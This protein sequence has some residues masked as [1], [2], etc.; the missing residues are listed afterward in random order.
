MKYIVTKDERGIEGIFLFPRTYNHDFFAEVVIGI[1][2][3]TNN[4][5]WERF[6]PLP[7]SAGFVSH[8]LKCFGRSETLGLGSRPEQDTRLLR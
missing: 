6:C 1:R 2:S 7:I 3:E 5:G 4:G 8:K